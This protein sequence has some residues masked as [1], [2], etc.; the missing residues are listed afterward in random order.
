MAEKQANVKRA[1]DEIMSTVKKLQQ[2]KDYTKEQKKEYIDAELSRLLDYEKRSELEDMGAG[3]RHHDRTHFIKAGGSEPKTAGDY[4]ERAW[5][6][7]TNPF[8]AA[9]YSI[10]GGGLENMPWQYNKLKELGY[11]PS[12]QSYQERFSGSDKK[13]NLVG[14]AL[15]S[16]NLLDAGDKTYGHIKK[17]NWSDAGL[18]AM[19]FLEVGAFLKPA[20]MIGKVAKAE[21]MLNTVDNVPLENINQKSLF[22]NTATNKSPKS[23]K[24]SFDDNPDAFEKFAMENPERVRHDVKEDWRGIAPEKQSRELQAKTFDM[25]TD[26]GNRWAVKDPQKIADLQNQYWQTRRDGSLSKSD[27]RITN[28][29]FWKSS[30]A[31]SEFLKENNLNHTDLFDFETPRGKEIQERYNNYNKDYM[32]KNH[33]ELFEK[34][35]AIVKRTT[36]KNQQLKN[37][38]DAIEENMDPEFRRK[39]LDLYKQSDDTGNIDLSDITVG[40]F[41]PNREPVL[42]Y[43]DKGDTSY[44]NLPEVDKQYLDD[45]WDDIGGVRTEYNTITLGSKPKGTQYVVQSDVPLQQ[46]FNF[47]KPNTW[48]NPFVKSTDVNNLDPNKTEIVEVAH[49]KMIDPDIVGGVNAHEIGHDHQK[50]YRSWIDLLQRYDPKYKYY[51]GHDK[52]KLAKTFQDALV[53]P[54][55][56]VKGESTYDT[57]LSGAGEVHSEL[58]KARFKTAKHYV[59]NDGLSLEDAIH[60]VKSLEAKGDDALYEYYL[61]EGNLDKHFKKKTSKET[62]KAMLKILP[63]A[64]PAIGTAAAVATGGDDPSATNVQ[65]QKYGG[66]VED[67]FKFFR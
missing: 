27:E 52:N 45:N 16:L 20:Q 57:W 21:N 40:D 53:N 26:F 60:Y 51:T 18:E 62:K 7:A 65:Q 1:G 5:D 37:I 34:R 46:K 28:D 4:A 33:P 58:M 59:D 14:D 30:E 50:L 12:A 25:A 17:G 67:L 49:Q 22:G 42:V 29:Y 9:K 23:Y 39:V 8:D 3:L 56:P 43:G 63:M 32:A 38:E 48:K 47:Y 44:V 61:K 55:D 11:D 13:S 41:N 2:N 54:T 24:Y 10:S 64:I 15:N 19:R 6:I 36:E 35:E 66:S 31:E